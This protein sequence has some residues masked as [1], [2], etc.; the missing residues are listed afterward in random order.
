[1]AT[2]G[3]SVTGDGT[4]TGSGTQDTIHTADAG[5]KEETI[6]VLLKNYSGSTRT[7]RAY[8][9]T[10]DDEGALSAAAISLL[11]HEYAV[12][13]GT[14]AP[15]DVLKIEGSAATSLAWTKFVR[16]VS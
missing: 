2:L 14:L 3:T 6:T 13:T 7:F 12:I 10:V 11:T 15:N 8:L 1:M 4:L 5:S 9:N 16:K